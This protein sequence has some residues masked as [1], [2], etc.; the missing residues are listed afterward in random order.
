M[1]L[2]G[3]KEE[4]NSRQCPLGENIAVQQIDEFTTERGNSTKLGWVF[5]MGRE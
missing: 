5:N 2:E 4:S 1:N 3:M